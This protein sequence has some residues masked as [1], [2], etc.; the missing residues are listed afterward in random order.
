MDISQLLKEKRSDILKVAAE[1]GARN[2]RVFGSAAR[3][4]ATQGSDLDLLVELEPGRT[5]L[6]HAGLLLDLQDLLGVDVDV[7]TE[8]GIKERMRQRVLEEAVEL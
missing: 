6:D 7:V 4:E 5:L 2:I 3:G 8:K 1:H